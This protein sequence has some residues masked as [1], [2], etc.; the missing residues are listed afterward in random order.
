M[1]EAR[2]A[3]ATRSPLGWP[4]RRTIRAMPTTAAPAA[5]ADRALMAK[6]PIGSRTATIASNTGTPGVREGK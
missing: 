4:S 3:S 1:G 2:K 5:V 6:W